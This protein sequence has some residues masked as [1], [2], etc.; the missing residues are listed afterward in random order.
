MLLLVRYCLLFLLLFAS[1][2][3]SRA[4]AADQSHF[5]GKYFAGEGDHEYLELLNTAR[6]MFEPDAKRQSLPMLYQPLWNGFT[7]G[8]TWNM[9]W[10][11]NTYGPSLA[12]L[13][14]LEE[15]YFTFLLNA[16]DLWFAKMG[17]GKRLDYWKNVGPD[18]CLCDAASP[19]NIF[20]KQGDGDVASHDWGL[21]FTAAAVVIQS[22]LLLVSRDP[23]L[24]AKYVPLLERSV[25]FVWSRRDP[26]NNLYLAGPAANLLAPSYGG[27]L[28][29]DGK[30]DKAYLAGLS[31]TMAAALGRM[32]EI[33]KL[34][35][36][37]AAAQQMNERRRLTIVGLQ[38]LFTPEGYL[39]KSLDP[40]G[41]RHGVY[42]A[43]KYG[44]FEAVANID[45]VAHR[46]ANDRQAV[47]ILAKIRAISG[48][49]PHDLLITN[50]PGL[51]DMYSPPQGIW[52][53]GHWINGG[54]WSTV[55][56]RAQMA[57]Y[58]LGAYDDA[59]RSMKAILKY[60]NRFRLD[61]NLTDFGGDVY[62]PKE[63]V[64]TVY[65]SWG[66]PA[67]FLRGLF[68]YRYAHDRL[69]IVPHI[70]PTIR[71]LEQKYPVRFGT[72][73]IYLMIAGSG[74]I[75]AVSVNGRPCPQF[76][77][78]EVALLEKDLPQKAV[79]QISRGAP[80][81]FPPLEL[82]IEE[83][84]LDCFRADE[85]PKDLQPLLKQA[86]H[87]DAFLKTFGRQDQRSYEASHARLAR[88]MIQ[89]TLKR[90]QLGDARWSG[91]NVAESSR[92]AAD[93]LYL[94]TAT[95]LY[96]G[97]GAALQARAVKGPG[98]QKLLKSWQTTQVR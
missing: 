98:E 84:S 48:L 89:V 22:E 33:E 28:R 43:P 65:D 51:D 77:E 92:A 78:S 15:P 88:Q 55:E 10:V 17:D 3:S 12:A 14:M 66:V 97:L 90:W 39:I 20:Y 29:P 93:Q 8:P 58:R 7:L 59:R 11:Q 26:K 72:K 56:A 83:I 13:P 37:Q 45:A 74:P 87:L 30:R 36:N 52:K 95:K 54:H 21:E 64:N 18:G 76:N 44:Y 1:Q 24:L 96:H 82:P 40:D 63:P 62:Q 94:S 91:L 57:Y 81:M 2:S 79:V 68:E 46:V 34:V 61:N 70:P 27:Y 41:T 53:F 9:W 19:D 73:Q 86:L 71:S 35:G 80:Q 31:V 38:Q 75:V 4:V 50:Y 25:N 60:A 42:G 85:L 47:Q 32:E 16:N 67:G 6:Q 23:Q 49:R 69:T 5:D